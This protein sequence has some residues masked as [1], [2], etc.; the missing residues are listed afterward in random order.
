MDIVGRQSYNCDILFR[1]I[2]IRKING[3]KVAIL[4]GEDFR[5]VAD[6]PYDGFG[7]H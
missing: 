1:V 4:Y 3:Q 7:G 2:D 6:A 5:L